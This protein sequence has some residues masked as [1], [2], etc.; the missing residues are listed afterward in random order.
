MDDNRTEWERDFDESMDAI[1]REEGYEDYKDFA[2][3]YDGRD[4]EC[5]FVEDG[6]IASAR[7]WE[8]ITASWCDYDGPVDCDFVENGSIASARE[9]EEMT[10]NW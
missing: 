9:W 6:S 5:D 10:A 7:E 4:P 3:S 2:R 1:A 8:E